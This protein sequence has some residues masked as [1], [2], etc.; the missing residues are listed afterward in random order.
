[1]GKDANNRNKGNVRN[2]LGL[3]KEDLLKMIDLGDHSGANQDV[4]DYGDG[5]NNGTGGDGR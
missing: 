3:L 1:M 2:F 5:T 4:G